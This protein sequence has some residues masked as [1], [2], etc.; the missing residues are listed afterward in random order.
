MIN[1]K[2]IIIYSLVIIIISLVL[3]IFLYS[4]D[5]KKHSVKTK[6]KVQFAYKIS[7][8]NQTE[9]GES[10][11][12]FVGNHIYYRLLPEKNKPW[13]PYVANKI[14]IECGDKKTLNLPTC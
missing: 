9:Y 6:L 8:I 7:S 14:S 12:V 13:I 10:E 2:N 5:N 4:L 3:T 11:S 1:R